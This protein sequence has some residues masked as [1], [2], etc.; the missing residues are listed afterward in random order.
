[1]W[2]N[3]NFPRDKKFGRLVLGW[4][5]TVGFLAIVTGVFFGILYGKGKQ[6]E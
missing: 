5:L 1:M 2:E 3:I 4:S 6:V